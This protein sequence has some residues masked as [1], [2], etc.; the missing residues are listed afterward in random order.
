MIFCIRAKHYALLRIKFSENNDLCQKVL[1][2]L[3][4]TC[5][6]KLALLRKHKLKHK[7]KNGGKHQ[8][9]SFFVK[10]N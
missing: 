1:E 2:L 7:I 3:L 9:L 4:R 8:T 10:A 5:V 6:N